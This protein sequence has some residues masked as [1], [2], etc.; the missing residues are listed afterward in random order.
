[1]KLLHKWLLAT[2]AGAV[3]IFVWGGISHM[4]LFKGV[5]FSRISD[6]QRI[7]TALRASLPGDGL[8]FIPNIDLRGNPTDEEKT[9]WEARFRAGPTG[10][11]IYHAAGDTPVSP[12]KVSVQF[13]SHLLAAGILSYLLSF[14]SG[15]YWKRVWLAGLL[16]AFGLFAISTIYWNWYGFPNDFFL[17]QGVDMIVGWSLAGTVIAKIILPARI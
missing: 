17:A 16:G 6:E 11:I 4:V 7:V 9:A 8:Y 14:T 12:K 15:S 2:L 3:T 10:L 13:L 1:M 5:G